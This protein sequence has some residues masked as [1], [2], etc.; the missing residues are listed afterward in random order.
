MATV[1]FAGPALSAA[2]PMICQQL[3]IIQLCPHSVQAKVSVPGSVCTAD[4][5]EFGLVPV[6]ELPIVVS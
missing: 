5:G 2:L 3:G 4:V 1:R 6:T